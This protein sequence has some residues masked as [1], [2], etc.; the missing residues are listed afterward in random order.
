MSE[1]LRIFVEF[2]LVGAAVYFYWVWVC[3]RGERDESE[4]AF[5]SVSYELKEAHAEIERLRKELVEL[6]SLRTDTDKNIKVLIDKVNQAIR[7]LEKSE[8]D[9]GE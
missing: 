5:V 2:V 9:G 7:L 3:V 1:Y 4:K 6:K 8:R